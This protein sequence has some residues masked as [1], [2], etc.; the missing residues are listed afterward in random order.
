MRCGT[1]AIISLMASTSGSTKSCSLIIPR[2]AR[3]RPL[4]AHR[5]SHRESFRLRK[6]PAHAPEYKSASRKWFARIRV[7]GAHHADVPFII[8]RA[9]V[10]LIRCGV[11]RQQGEVD[12]PCSSWVTRRSGSTGTTRT[13]I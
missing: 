11:R 10:E 9:A 3:A 1:T 13:R 7:I 6:T 4:P 2:V 5:R 8:K 12:F